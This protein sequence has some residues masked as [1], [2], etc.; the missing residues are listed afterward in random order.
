[1]MHL[2]EL[3][4][5][6]PENLH[7]EATFLKVFKA[8]ESE[9]SPQSLEEEER[10]EVEARE[11]EICLSACTAGEE[12]VEEFGGDAL[13]VFRRQQINSS[14]CA[15]NWRKGKEQSVFRDNSTSKKWSNLERTK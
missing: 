14:P 6:S 15:K 5:Q 4:S 10:Q 7:G 13:R 8:W 11:V 2:R 9:A 1:M 12:G 3:C